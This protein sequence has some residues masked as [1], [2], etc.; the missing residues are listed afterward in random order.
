MLAKNLYSNAEVTFWD[1][2]I[3]V[4][5]GFIWVKTHKRMLLGLLFQ[6]VSWASIGFLVG[7]L[8]GYLAF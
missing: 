2:I 8:A 6:T 5:S 4:L 7:L 1:T 3:V